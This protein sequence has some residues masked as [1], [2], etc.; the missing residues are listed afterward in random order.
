MFNKKRS[1]STFI[2]L[3][4]LKPGI[5]SQDFTMAYRIRQYSR[6]MNTGHNDEQESEQDG[7][8]FNINRKGFAFIVV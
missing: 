8:F 1:R 5:D 6:F 4:S 3:H 2:C 7:L